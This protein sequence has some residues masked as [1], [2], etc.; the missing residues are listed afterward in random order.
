MQLA[1]GIQR[2]G[3]RK[4]YE[5][6]LMQSHAHLTLTLFSALGLMGALEAA[7]HFHTWQDQITDALA[8]IASS[9]IGLWS[10]RRYLYL[11]NHAEFVANQARCTACGT[12]ARFTLV[13]APVADRPVT[14]CC[15]QCQHRWAI[16]H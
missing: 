9:V 14:V 12:Y 4:W 11:L 3:F 13:G 5:R 2:Y 1:Q 16:E 7:T 8:L 10:L 15:K 6:Q